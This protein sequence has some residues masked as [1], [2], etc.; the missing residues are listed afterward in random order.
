MLEGFS[1][2]LHYPPYKVD[3]W[4]D[5]D[6]RL[7]EEIGLV[8]DLELARLLWRAAVANTLAVS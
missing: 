6:S 8:T 4:S 5:D 2:P 7:E 1:R 3:L